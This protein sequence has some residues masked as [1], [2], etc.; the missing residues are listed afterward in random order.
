ME[1]ALGV[2]GVEGGG[3]VGGGVGSGGGVGGGGEKGRGENPPPPPPPA[4]RISAQPLCLCVA[5]CLSAPPCDEAS[6]LFVRLGVITTRQQRV[7][8]AGGCERERYCFSMLISQL[9]PPL[10]RRF[11]RPANK[12]KSGITVSAA[13]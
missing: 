3:G 11:V 2:A 1:E 5:A 12:N 13:H 8:K 7:N 6:L 10:L 9:M 4:H